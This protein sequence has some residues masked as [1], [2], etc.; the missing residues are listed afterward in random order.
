VAWGQGPGLKA[1]PD[2]K[3]VNRLIELMLRSAAIDVVGIWMGDD[4]GVLNP[5][6]V[7]L[8][9]GTVIPKSVGSA[10]LQP[11]KTGASYELSDSLVDRLH[12]NIRRAFFVTRIDEREMTAE[13]Y[14]GRTQQ[15]LRDQRVLYGQ[16]KVEFATQVQ[17]RVI[18]L[19]ME[20]GEVPAADYA[21]LAQI[22]L[23]GPLAMDVRGLEVERTKQAFADIAGLFGP[24]LAM[25]AVRP[26]KVVP[27]IVSRRYAE[28]DNFREEQELKAFGEQVLAMMA[29]AQAQQ[30]AQDPAKAVGAMAA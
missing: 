22:E 11:V 27:Y 14:R 9:P 5:H 26:E 29:Q 20:M 17:M 8:V 15:Q 1:L 16:L 24:E 28:P 21:R 2:V 30:M 12:A 19:G 6:N 13:E 4:D 3:V 10:G 18:D 23:T 7:K 25:A